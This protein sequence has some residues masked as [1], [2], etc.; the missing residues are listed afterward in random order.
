LRF[1]LRC[2][3]QAGTALRLMLPSDPLGAQG[4]H[5][6]APAGFDTSSRGVSVS[7]NAA[8]PIVAGAERSPA[9][10][11]ACMRACVLLWIA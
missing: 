4:M 9:R 1:A 6:G 11:H 8:A 7:G 2:T 5:A 3:Q 10:M